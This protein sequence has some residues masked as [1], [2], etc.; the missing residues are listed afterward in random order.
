VR[1]EGHVIFRHP[2]DGKV[3]LVFLTFIVPAN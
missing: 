1:L 2:A 3:S